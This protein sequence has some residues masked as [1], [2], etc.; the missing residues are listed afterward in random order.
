MSKKIVSGRKLDNVI[1]SD[2]ILGKDIIDSEGTVIGVAEKI[3]IDSRRLEFIGIEADKGFLQKGLV[4]GKGYIER[5][6]DYAIFLKKQIFF[7]LVGNVVFDKDGKKVGI[8][9]QVILKGT[10]NLVRS[11]ILKR[12]LADKIMGRYIEIPARAI[13]VL[14]EN[15]ILNVSKKDVESYRKK[16]RS[17]K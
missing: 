9:S 11:I 3:F 6:E 17:V 4:I 10:R 2:D 13:E 5:V 16:S 12:R 8:I 15:V 14:G 1:T 7:E